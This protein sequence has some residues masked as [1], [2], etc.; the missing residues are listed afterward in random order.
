MSISTLIGLLNIGI[1]VVAG[2]LMTGR[3]FSRTRTIEAFSGD[4]HVKTLE[5]LSSELSSLT[6]A[7]P[8]YNEEMKRV[9]VSTLSTLRT[10]I[11]DRDYALN[12]EI[13]RAR[14]GIYLLLLS[15]F[16]QGV[17]HFIKP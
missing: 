17:L 9:V 4:D 16:L 1:V 2:L 11:I 6:T 14:V 7:D 15:A 3:V 8:K 12:D 13:R 10:R 5:N